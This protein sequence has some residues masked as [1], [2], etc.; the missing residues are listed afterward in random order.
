MYSAGSMGQTSECSIDI[1]LS[2]LSDSADYV[3]EEAVPCLWW[4]EKVTNQS[5]ASFISV[6]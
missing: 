2:K 4:L 6:A 3:I 5:S 1:M